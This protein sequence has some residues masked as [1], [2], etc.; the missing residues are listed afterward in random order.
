MIQPQ[1]EWEE[2]GHPNI[3]PL[4]DFFEHRNLYYLILPSTL[5]PADA[6]AGVAPFPP[7]PNDLFDLVEQCPV[8]LPAHLVRS[9]LGQIA[10]AIAFLHMR[11]IVHRDIKDENVVFS[12]NGDRCWLI[13]FGSAG[14]VRRNGWNSFSGT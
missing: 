11:G 5:S 12:A 6:D 4:I 13:D 3:C 10:D 14:I 9:Y 2:A 8:G 1:W 7:P